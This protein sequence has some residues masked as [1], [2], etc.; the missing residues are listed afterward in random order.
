MRLTR[1]Q[2]LT[3]LA[4]GV[5]ATACAPSVS[6][7][8]P[9][10][11]AAKKPDRV[12]TIV[13]GTATAEPLPILNSIDLVIA[14]QTQPHDALLSGVP[15]TYDWHKGP[16][17][18][19]GSTPGKLRAMTAWGQIYAAAG[20]AIPRNTRVQIAD[21]EAWMLSKS[22]RR[23]IQLQADRRVAGAA[24]REDFVD[25][26]SIPADVRT[27][28]DGSISIRLT[29]GYNYHFWPTGG[30]VR[31]DNTDVAGMFTTVRARLISDDEKQPDD[32]ADA[33]LLLGMGG[34]YWLDLDTAWDATWQN[35]GDIAI[36]R[37][38]WVTPE[39]QAFSMTSLAA[40]ALRANPPPLR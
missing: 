21:I 37:L 12:P 4:L 31:F 28:A 10:A 25:N 14:D 39:W 5:S 18:G 20:S 36:G 26:A 15:T 7:A 1:R 3:L 29:R 30:R 9:A 33:K 8:A 24:Y 32:R 22:T 34:D 17:Q 35:V 11:T 13:L 40:D 16:R 19:R 6:T 38:K 27:E 23:W 2:I